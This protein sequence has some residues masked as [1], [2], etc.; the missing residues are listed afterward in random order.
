MC[1]H[2][3]NGKMHFY[4]RLNNVIFGLALNLFLWPKNRKFN[5]KT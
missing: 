2:I 3:K 5:P 4:A 1:Y